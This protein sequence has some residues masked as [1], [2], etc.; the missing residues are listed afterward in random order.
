MSFDPSYFDDFGNRAIGFG[1]SEFSSTRCVGKAGVLTC[2]L[3]PSYLTGALA[4][5]AK[6]G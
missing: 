6:L 4:I 5:L 1:F 3:N 2:Q